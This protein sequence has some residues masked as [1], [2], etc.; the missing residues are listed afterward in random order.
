ML[1]ACSAEHRAASRLPAQDAA[2]PNGDAEWEAGAARE[3]DAAEAAALTPTDAAGAQPVLQSYE[4]FCDQRARAD[5]KRL[6]QCCAVEPRLD[7]CLATMRSYRWDREHLP[8]CTSQPAIASV[9]LALATEC[10]ELGER[11]YDAC[12]LS[13]ADAQPRQEAERAC[14]ALFPEKLLPANGTCPYS[15][16][17]AQR[18]ESPAGTLSQ[19]SPCS[20]GC[21][22]RCSA[23][24]ALGKRGE[25]CYQPI[26]CAQGLV[27]LGPAIGVKACAPPAA[28]GSPCNSDADC[29]SGSCPGEAS[30][31]RSCAKLPPAIAGERCERARVLARDGLYR[32]AAPFWVLGEHLL[33]LDATKLLRARADGSSSAPEARFTWPEAFRYM[34]IEGSAQDMQHLWLLQFS[35]IL[36]LD[37]TTLAS[38]K[39]LSVRGRAIASAAGA[40]WVAEDSCARVTKVVDGSPGTSWSRLLESGE[41]VA[42]TRSVLAALGDN[43]YCAAGN[44]LWRPEG[45]QLV[46]V[47]RVPNSES[48]EAQS[49]DYAQPSMDNLWLFTRATSG[50]LALFKLPAGSSQL[51]QLALPAETLSSLYNNGPAVDAS[52]GR[53]Y[54]MDATG[55]LRVSLSDGS[56]E[57]VAVP[58]GGSGEPVTV[59]GSFVYWY[60]DGVLYRHPLF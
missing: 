17:S 46:P 27:C 55:L 13:R 40:L 50:Q 45:T 32:A 52:S 33:W 11:S 15:T 53:I 41:F 43:V 60:L 22:G 10:L 25:R 36:E 20:D 42:P 6:T 39:P 30:A 16:F 57:R 37:L 23:P 12:Q 31:A 8:S 49:V 38:A 26:D 48:G 19:C 18:C 35:Q 29:A 2:S 9:D 44:T 47:L 58:N 59:A 4:E 24:R 56:V 34:N 21:I 28:D 54:A 14:T 3:D 51:T 1:A 5:C 7:L